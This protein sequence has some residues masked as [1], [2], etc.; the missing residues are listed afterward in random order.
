MVLLE[1]WEVGITPTGYVV[2]TNDYRMTKKAKVTDT[3]QKTRGSAKNH[4]LEP[5]LPTSNMRL[6]LLAILAWVLLYTTYVRVCEI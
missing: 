4:K 6:Q 1:S 5:Q 3:L 2:V